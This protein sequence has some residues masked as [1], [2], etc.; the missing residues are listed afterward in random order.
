[1]VGRPES[2]DGLPARHGAAASLR[3]SPMLTYEQR[4][5]ADLNWALSEGSRF[6]EG[7]CSVQVA[8]RK[9]AKR[10]NDLRIPYVVVGTL[11]FF[12]HGYRRFTEEV[13][14][15]VSEEG[16]R[17]IHEELDGF[18]YLPASQCSKHLRDAD[19]GVKIKFLVEGQF[20]GDGKPNPVA[21][22]NPQGASVEKDEIH[23]LVLPKLIELKLASGMIHSSRLRD[24]A[25]VFDAIQVLG[26][27][28]EFGDQ[29]NPFVRSKFNELW[30]EAQVPD[31]LE[32]GNYSRP[33]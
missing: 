10:L 30:S 28:K 21:F 5:N 16:L 27:P 20:A 6:F 4:L 29:L 24:L 26:L 8:M 31:P 22:P 19:L 11:A 7:N 15:L 18:G 12:K 1:M 32:Q 3:G 25:D 33:D 9:I 17:R 23:Y 13:E 14:L 2:E